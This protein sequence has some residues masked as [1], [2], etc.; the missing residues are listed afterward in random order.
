[1]H[2]FLKQ[3]AK[4]D[5]PVFVTEFDID[6]SNLA[7]KSEKREKQV[8]QLCRDYLKNVLKHLQVTA[9]LAWGM[10]SHPAREKAG[11]DRASEKQHIAL[12]FDENLRPTPFLSAMIEA[13][14]KR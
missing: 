6:N 8:A 5:L 1:M 12:P 9:V 3:V 4:L 14:E 11:F 13:I 10:V 7:A 2:A